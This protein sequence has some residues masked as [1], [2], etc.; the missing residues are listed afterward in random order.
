MITVV[1]IIIVIHGLDEYF[2]IKNVKDIGRHEKKNRKAGWKNKTF[3]VNSSEK[4]FN[5][6]K[7][8]WQF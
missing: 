1:M 3:T 7:M 2:A 4:T 8:F 6:S 5:K